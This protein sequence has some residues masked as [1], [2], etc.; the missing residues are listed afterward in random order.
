MAGT[1]AGTKGIIRKVIFIPMSIIFIFIILMGLISPKAFYN[2]ENAI[3]NF[4]YDW[5]GWLYAVMAI[6]SVIV[7]TWLAFS[8]HG[9]IILGGPDAKPLDRKSVV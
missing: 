8:K 6:F 1:A 9:D 3:S 5:F 7:L 4:Q 2:V